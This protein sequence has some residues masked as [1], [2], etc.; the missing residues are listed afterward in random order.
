MIDYGFRYSIGLVLETGFTCVTR[1][2]LAMR[3]G[4]LSN[5]ARMLY[6]LEVLGYTGHSACRAECD[7][8]CLNPEAVIDLYGNRTGGHPRS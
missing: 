2:R 5:E 8:F 6:G 4:D 7:G 3:D 1:V